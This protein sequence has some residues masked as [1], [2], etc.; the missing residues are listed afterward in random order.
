[1]HRYQRQKDRSRD[2]EGRDVC[3]RMLTYADVCRYQ[4]QK[5]RGRDL[6]GRAQELQA[7]LDAAKAQVY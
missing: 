5:D 3:W 7:K 6:E 1:M 4:R 2:L